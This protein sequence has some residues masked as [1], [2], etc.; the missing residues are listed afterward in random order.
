M[1]LE[2]KESTAK[3]LFAVSKNQCA[4]PDCGQRLVPNPNTNYG[5][6]CHIR[7]ENQGSKRYDN[8]M[9]KEERRD[10]SNIILLCSQCHIT[11]DS[12]EITYPVELLQKWKKE[13]ES[14]QGKPFE[15]SK[16]LLKI[17]IVEEKIKVEQINSQNSNQ[18]VVTGEKN[19]AVQ[20][21]S[22]QEVIALF[23]SMIGN[24][25]KYLQETRQQMTQNINN[26]AKKFVEIGLGQISEED[27]V[28]LGEPDLQHT[29]ENAVKI[30][31]RKDAH[32]IHEVLANLIV[33]RIQSKDELDDIVFNEAISVMGK[34]TDNQLKI[35]A[36][37]FILKNTGWNGGGTQKE[38][39]HVYKTF[40]EPLFPMKI[41]PTQLGYIQSI[42]CGSVGI[43]SWNHL[44][45]FRAH[46][47]DVFI[48][49]FSK[50]ELPGYNI[51]KEIYEQIFEEKVEGIVKCKFSSESS[52][53]KFLD[54]KNI[55]EIIKKRILNAYNNKN[56][57]NPEK[58]IKKISEIIPNQDFINIIKKDNELSHFS[59]TAIG[60]A[61]AIT[62]LKVITKQNFDHK[63]WI[64]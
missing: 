17:I 31:S 11:I 56:P 39:V 50:L 42:S 12:D 23:H 52:L 1:V 45:Y 41:S 14:K 6:L 3:K 10:Y 53:R 47:S 29:L 20:G 60:M 34:L 62:Y 49:N 2:I 36:V 37:S 32:E 26:F 21:F 51:P 5:Q 40:F 57:N 7:G 63:I 19:I 38:L 64:N 18:L 27:K 16:E 46:F 28:K 4:N 55:E 33:K 9:N 22:A 35:I 48:E 15:L 58:I 24:D 13:H 25:T 43:G 44:E 54:K 8:L 59:L 61:I 30:A